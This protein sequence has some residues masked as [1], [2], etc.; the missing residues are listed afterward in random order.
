MSAPVHPE[1]VREIREQ[2]AR[3]GPGATVRALAAR[4]GYATRTIHRI[5]TGALQPQAGGPISPSGNNRKGWNHLTHEEKV[6]NCRKA[7]KISAR[8]RK[9]R[10]KSAPERHQR[11]QIRPNLPPNPGN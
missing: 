3:G 6:E 5:I 1:D 7:A 11:P 4:H 10:L 9:N 8:N 2:Y